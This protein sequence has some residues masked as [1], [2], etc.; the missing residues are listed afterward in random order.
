MCLDISDIAGDYV[1]R[2]NGTVIVNCFGSWT[3]GVCWENHIS[4]YMETCI[5]TWIDK[6]GDVHS[7]METCTARR[8]AQIGPR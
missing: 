2:P 3:S 6:Y 4:T 5:A 8:T 7:N 1:A